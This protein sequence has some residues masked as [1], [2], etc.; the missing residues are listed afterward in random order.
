MTINQ[1][2]PWILPSMCMSGIAA[3]IYLY[4]R[5]LARTDENNEH[6]VPPQ[7]IVWK[8][9]TIGDICAWI[10]YIIWAPVFL[11]ITFN[12]L[13]PSIL[14]YLSN[15]YATSE[16]YKAPLHVYVLVIVLLTLGPV[17]SDAIR[18]L[19]NKKF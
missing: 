8:V 4:V 16:D 18:I 11:F 3:Y 6:Y 19:V 1:F 2:L 12:I 13:G 7:K 15:P 5:A 17:G 10:Y 9:F 14:E